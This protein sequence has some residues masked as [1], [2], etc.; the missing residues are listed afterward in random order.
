[1]RELAAIAFRAS[2]TGTMELARYR[3]S[4]LERLLA[5]WSTRASTR[6]GSSRA[7]LRLRF[8]LRC[9]LR[10]RYFFAGCIDMLVLAAVVEFA[11][12]IFTE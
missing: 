2:G 6:R 5:G 4:L 1:M 9:S 12:T 11:F 3:V 10:L 7:F 8:R